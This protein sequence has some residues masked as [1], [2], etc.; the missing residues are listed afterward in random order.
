MDVSREREP[1]DRTAVLHGDEHGS[2]RMS[3]DR[4]EIP[5]LVGEAPPLLRGQEPGAVLLADRTPQFDECPGIS[6]LGR[7]DRDHGTTIP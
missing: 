3:S 1:A 7:S 6:R 4:A 5:S 2:V